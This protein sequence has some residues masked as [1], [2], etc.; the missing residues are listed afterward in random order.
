MFDWVG[1]LLRVVYFYSHFIGLSNF[2]YDWRTGR[3]FTSLR[4][5]LQAI[6]IN[7]LTVMAL[8]FYW[9]GQSNAN[10]VFR[11]ANKLHE[12]VVIIMSGLRIT[13]G[14]VTVLNRWLQRSQTMKLSREIVCLYMA[15][16]Q[17][18]KMI[19]WGLLLKFF[20]GGVTDLFQ[21]VISVSAL[22]QL[23]S[24]AIVGVTL[25]TLI[26]FILNLAISQHYFIILFVRGQYEIVNIKLRQVI[27]ES[28]RLSYLQR[29][30][31]AFM[32]RCCHL[33][34]Q[35]EDI[36]KVQ[37]QLQSILVEVAE[38]FGIQGLMAYAGYYISC[39]GD[40]YM[41]YS[42]YR[43]GPETLNMSVRT[44]FLAGSWCFFYYLDGTINCLNMLYVRDH[45]NK[46]LR[47]LEERT[48]FASR[49]DVRLEE[50]FES[51]Q[52]QLLQKPLTMDIMGMFPITRSATAAMI[53]S[54][55]ANSIFLIQFDMEYF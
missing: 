42:I 4:T 51:L 34:D 31:G 11:S 52:L 27:I 15:N 13:A 37:S 32:T 49:L 20:T 16:P 2:V 7:A 26:S 5:T 18:K 44:M 41:T 12:Y 45:H 35:L 46:M 6:T 39:I 48:V 43:Y 29:R 19:R 54:I 47:L 17:V 38:I 28:L 25:H 10:F 22:G 9:T 23:D 21:V 50:S 3:V 30:E 55:I 33:S 1:L 36:G 8:I 53:G 14:L 40:Y 24:S